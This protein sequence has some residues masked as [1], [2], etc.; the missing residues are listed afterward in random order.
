M[1]ADIG[2][3]YASFLPGISV[4]LCKIITGDTKQGYAVT[5]VSIIPLES[6]LM[7]LPTVAKTATHCIVIENVLLL[8][9]FSWLVVCYCVV[10]QIM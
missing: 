10:R 1:K 7:L 5:T 9:T 3:I 2:N 4:T 8:V 6:F